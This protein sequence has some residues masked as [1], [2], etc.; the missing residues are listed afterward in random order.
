MLKNNSRPACSWSSPPREISSSSWLLLSTLYQD[1]S[2]IDLFVGGAAEGE[3]EE[4]EEEGAAMGPT[5]A[6]IVARQFRAL[7]DGDR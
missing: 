5:F 3:E 2:D 6:C 1:P 7:K 4:E